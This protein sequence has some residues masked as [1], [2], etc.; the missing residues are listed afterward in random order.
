MVIS[1]WEVVS[2]SRGENRLSRRASVSLSFRAGKTG[3]RTSGK[4]TIARRKLEVAVDRKEA[5]QRVIEQLRGK[6]GGGSALDIAKAF[7]GPRA[8]RH[9]AEQLTMIGL[10]IAARLSGSG[11]IQPTRGNCFT[12]RR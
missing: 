4:R 2:S 9:K 10:G 3:G 8:R 11:Q 6:P 7:L 1:I 12:V 5:D